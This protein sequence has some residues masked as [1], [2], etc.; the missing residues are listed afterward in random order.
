MKKV[1]SSSAPQAVGA[2]SQAISTDNLLFISCQLGLHPETGV[3]VEG[4]IEAETQQA[5]ANIKAVLE[6]ANLS[7]ANVVKVTVLLADIQEFNLMNAVYSQTF[8]EPYP[9]RSA[10][11][12]AA[13]PK[14]GR[15][16]IEVIAEIE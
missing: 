9:A 1:S 5:L 6:A 11:A 14:G 8:E 3:I 13:L 12:V 15:V 10:Y 4:G 16:G 7:L 2:Y